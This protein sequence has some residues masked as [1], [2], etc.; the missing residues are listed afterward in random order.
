MLNKKGAMFGLDAR[1]ALAIF[2]ALSVISGAALYSAIKQAKVTAFVADMEEL[3][4]S[5]E[6]YYLDTGEILAV[7]SGNPSM[8]L[9]VDGLFNK[10][11]NV[12]NWNGPYSQL[13]QRNAGAIDYDSGT[14][15]IPYR[16]VDAPT[17]CTVG[18]KKCRIY[19]W[20]AKSNSI[21]FYKSVEKFVDGTENP[22][23]TSDSDGKIRYS[24]SSM[25]YQT[26]III[27]NLN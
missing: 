15:T 5:I 2:G 12:S 10:P 4:K 24:T 13:S 6:Q 18:T 19:I 27:N 23:D 20:F 16:L 1:I 9:G 14:I 22:S 3:A 21:D 11:A 25:F 26:D 7:S 8:D 17:A